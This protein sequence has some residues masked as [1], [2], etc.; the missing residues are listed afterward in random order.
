MKLPTMFIAWSLLMTINFSVSAYTPDK[1]NYGIL[2]APQSLKISNR[3]CAFSGSAVLSLGR[4]VT[5]AD[6]KAVEEFIAWAGDLKL[7]NFSADSGAGAY[8]ITVA[9]ASQDTEIENALKSA[10][11]EYRRKSNVPGGYV[12]L[13][14]EQGAV[15]ASETEQGRFYGLMTLV[16]Y[17]HGTRNMER[18]CIVV[19]D[20]P[21]LALRGISDD[22]SRGQASTLDDFKLLIRTI[23][24][25]KM[26]VFMPYM[27]DMFRFKSQPGIG[28][29]R[30]AF[31]PGEIADLESFA[32]DYHV[33]VIPIFQTLGHYENILLKDE[34]K[35]LAEFPGAASLS[36]AEDKTYEFLN[37]VLSEIVPAFSDS[38][39]N[40]ACDESWDVGLGKS[41]A[42]KNKLGTSGV[43]AQHYKKVY[44][45]VKE[46]G[47]EVMMYGDILLHN[48]KILGMIPRDITIVDWHYNADHSY[49]S[50]EKLRKAGF[51][52][53]VSPGV[54]N[55]N[56]IYPNFKSAETNIRN[57]TRDGK[58]NGAKGTIT[59]SWGDNGAANL[60][61]LNYWGYI[62][63]AAAAWRPEVCD[64]DTIAAAFWCSF[65][66]IDNPEDAL[67]LNA[68]LLSLS[69]GK[70]WPLYEWWRHPLNSGK[71]D[72]PALRADDI[73][74][75]MRQASVHLENIRPRART[76]LWYLDLIDFIIHFGTVHANKQAWHAQY[77]D[78]PAGAGDDW[79]SQRADAAEKLRVETESVKERY[80]ET[81]LRFNRPEGLDNNLKMFDRLI[82]QWT[83]IS[84]GEE[85]IISNIDNNWIAP[86]GSNDLD[87][88]KSARSSWIVHEFTVDGALPSEALLQLMGMNRCE[89]FVNGSP[90]G[91]TVGRW[92]LSLIVEDSRARIVDVTKYLKPGVNRISVRVTNYDGRT[93]GANIYMEMYGSA[94][95]SRLVASGPEWRSVEAE[96][97]PA[98]WLSGNLSGGIWGVSEVY[99]P[100][101]PTSK[102][103]L[104]QGINS[105]FER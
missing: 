36:P 88:R 70:G 52:V 57:L 30:G 55:W 8:E 29:G 97:E 85:E 15:I 50:V 19:E 32:A 22:I 82:A 7:G 96:T 101:L 56:R 95:G 10:G 76:N 46:M 84:R 5:A 92:T 2:P 51:E 31:T 68:A 41:R 42:L 33:R 43:H 49:P 65:L 77:A 40:I 104:R 89:V 14:G 73:L 9:A 17:L 90:V 34:Y 23:S 61:Q 47:R 99:D 21:E 25:Y 35:D 79:F 87:R 81:W 48:P 37:S 1:Y 27:E 16:Q 28:E 64:P 45:M 24:R 18:P 67:Q 105:R 72:D 71:F 102:P 12:M 83:E 93:P 100:G 60:R 54:S 44:D 11:V 63:G 80:A 6:N 86:K 75:N 13:V 4:G 66:G 103:F 39:F 26:N 74:K 59:S 91:E 53:V 78:I 94:R 20:Y 58:A 3:Q 69:R 98:G 38:F 62:Y